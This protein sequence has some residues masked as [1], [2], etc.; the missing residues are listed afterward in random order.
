MHW[1]AARALTCAAIVTLPIGAAYA[2][3]P[4]WV[5]DPDEAFRRSEATGKPVVV[6][7][8]ADWCQP[9][10]EMEATTWSDP[11]VVAALAGFVPLKLDSDRYGSFADRYRAD[12]LPTTLVLD[13]EG[14]PIV[15]I[16]GFVG[17]A[18][19][20]RSLRVVES[21]YAGYL[22]GLSRPGDVAAAEKVSQF[23]YEVG[24][25][26]GAARV[27]RHASE[28]ARTNGEPAARVEAIELKRAQMT[29]AGGDHRGGIELLAGLSES[30]TDPR[31]RSWALA[32]L[33]ET[34]RMLG[35]EAGAEAALAR[36]RTEFPDVARQL[37]SASGGS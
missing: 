18:S 21:G 9:C 17:P 11:Q 2:G 36:L 7:V 35:D 32:G 37:E 23:L 27:L 8:F 5:L 3:G 31:V 20:L 10:H 26:A 6:D 33:V 25:P 24:N 19:I 15:S 22:E 28:T 4:D 12:T 34:R 29:F 16:P 30:A 13:A 14:R 1:F